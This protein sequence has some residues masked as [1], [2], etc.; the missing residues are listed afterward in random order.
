MTN[1]KGEN[2]LTFKDVVILPERCEGWD[3]NIKPDS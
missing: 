1:Y 3:W 2:E